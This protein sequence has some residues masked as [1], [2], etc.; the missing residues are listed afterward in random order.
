VNVRDSDAEHLANLGLALAL[1]MQINN[2]PLV[3]VGITCGDGIERR[4]GKFPKFGK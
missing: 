1:H 2:L 4:E 3:C